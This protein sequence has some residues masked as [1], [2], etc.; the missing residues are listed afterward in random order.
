MA[1][2]IIEEEEILVQEM[3]GLDELT[4]ELAE[5]FETLAGID[6]EFGACVFDP[7]M[8]E[9]QEKIGE[10]QRRKKIVQHIIDQLESLR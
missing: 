1:D 2:E 9:V 4:R 6:C 5:K 8:Q 3:D 10:V 7:E